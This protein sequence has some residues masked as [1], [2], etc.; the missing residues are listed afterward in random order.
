MA[1]EENLRLKKEKELDELKELEIAHQKEDQ[2]RS[3]LKQIEI[4]F[5]DLVF[6]LEGRPA[7]ISLVNQLKKESKTTLSLEETQKL[8]Q[9]IQ[10]Q[11]ILPTK[12]YIKALEKLQMSREIHS[13]QLTLDRYAKN[14]LMIFLDNSID[15]AREAYK[16]G[17]ISQAQQ[18]I[19]TAQKIFDKSLPEN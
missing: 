8:L 6:I 9:T 13:D 12:A 4:K 16:K 11:L 7:P 15:N 1:E 5:I 18:T 17:Q 10:E 3:V 14:N 2:R 19:N